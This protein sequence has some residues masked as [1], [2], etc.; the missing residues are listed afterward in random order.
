MRRSSTTAALLAVLLAALG[1]RIAGGVWWQSRHPG[2]FGFGDSLSYWTLGQA[3]AR[4][5]PF[6]YNTPEARV[7][8]TPGYPLVLAAMFKLLGEETSKLSGH[9]VSALLGALAV[10]EVFW[11]G[12]WLFDARTGLVAACLA[13]FYPGVVAMGVFILSEAPFCP[14][15]LAHLGLW[16]LAWRQSAG[17]SKTG[18]RS[19]AWAIVAGIAGGGATLMRPSWLL[20]TPFAIAAAMIFG[21]L[22]TK[23]LFIG[24][25]V[26]AAMCLT[27]A[28]W[29]I[30]N[31][32][33]TGHFVPT[34]LQVGASLYDGLNPAADGASDMSFVPRFVEQ[35]RRI[36]SPEDFEYRLDRRL[37]SAALAWAAEHPG[38]AIELAGIKFLRMWNVWPNEAE[39]RSWPLRLAVLVTYLPVLGLSIWGVWRFTRRGWPYVLCW[40]PAVYLTLLHVVFVSSIRYRDP[41]ILALLVLAAGIITQQGSTRSSVS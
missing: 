25:A 24:S 20:F 7:F 31:A 15:M 17:E 11:L 21:R 30:R 2:E 33:V 35:E 40:L 29:W 39:F 36:A 22:R 16:G 38:R 32:R 19:M 5:E 9:V 23:H 14:L 12:K 6:Q 10:G 37:R 4:G 28:P 18:W 1:A 26:M 34:T 3:I 27:L 8:R 13:A 41:A